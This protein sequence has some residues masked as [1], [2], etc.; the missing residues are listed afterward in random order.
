MIFIAESLLIFFILFTYKNELQY[1]SSG[2]YNL[3]RSFAAN[4]TCSLA[5][6]YGLMVGLS[7]L[8]VTGA[9]G[10]V[11]SLE[12]QSFQTPAWISAFSVLGSV[13]SSV[14]S[15]NIFAVLAESSVT[16]PAGQTGLLQVGVGGQ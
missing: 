13:N 6:R 3:R 1:F 8:T 9:A 12:F 16:V 5:K 10:A 2:V 11:Q 4:L 15:G 14:T 7:T